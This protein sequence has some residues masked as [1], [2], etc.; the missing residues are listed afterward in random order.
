[1]YSC[2]RAFSYWCISIS[3]RQWLW[4]PWK[5]PRNIE[6]RHANR[7][8]KFSPLKWIRVESAICSLREGTGL[9]SRFT[10]HLDLFREST[11]YVW[12]ILQLVSAIRPSYLPN[13][14][15]TRKHF[16]RIW[17]PDRTEWP[18]KQSA[19]ALLE[20]QITVSQQQ[21]WSLLNKI[22]GDPLDMISMRVQSSAAIQWAQWTRSVR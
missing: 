3:L 1:M 7:T 16:R 18:E 8:M 15:V 4:L 14:F 9:E 19:D 22:E 13:L 2:N 12:L 5:I 10:R 17:N 20:G 6:T 11:C 21:I